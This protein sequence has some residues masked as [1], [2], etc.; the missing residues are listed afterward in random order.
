MAF[1]QSIPSMEEDRATMDR[2]YAAPAPALLRQLE[3]ARG[4]GLTTSQAMR[5]IVKLAIGPGRLKP[6]EYFYYRLFEPSLT[7]A[8]KAAFIGKREQPWIHLACNDRSWTGVC[9][10]KLLFYTLMERL[11]IPVPK[12]LALYHTHRRGGEEVSHLRSKGDLRRFFLG[13]DQPVFAK[14]VDGVHSIGSIAVDGV[15]AGTGTA[16]LATGTQVAL[17]EIIQRMDQ[18]R[19]SGYLIQERVRPHPDLVRLC[20]PTLSCVRLIVLLGRNGPELL[21]TQFK[22]PVGSNAADNFWR[23]NMISAVD[24]DSGKILRVVKGT[25]S[26][27][28]LPTT[29]P[30]TGQ[31]LIGAVLPLWPEVKRLATEA[32]AAL[33][34]IRLQAWDIAISANGPVI[35]ECNSGGDFSAPQLAWGKGMLDERFRRFLGEQG[36]RPR[37]AL[38]IPLSVAKSAARNL[39]VM[40]KKRTRN[41]RHL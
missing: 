31:R 39:G 21:R 14:P 3:G 15:D 12:L 7:F 35:I 40:R 6:Q 20:G 10:D 8:Q 13:L 37:S 34:R 28:I 22:I 5:E 24:L 36:Y 17:D 27:Q 1:T 4:N 41:S 38:L 26:Q 18:S 32:A 29:H 11:R 25:G 9:N 33:P 30:D 2:I 19:A 23:G 16:S